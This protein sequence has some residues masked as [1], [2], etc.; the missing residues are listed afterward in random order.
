MSVINTDTL[1]DMGDSIVLGS[2]SSSIVELPRA[3]SLFVSRRTNLIESERLAF[4]GKLLSITDMT[5]STVL[6]V[7]ADIMQSIV[8]SG[9][10][11][12]MVATRTIEA[13]W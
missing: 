11:S 10:L 8:F 6:T 12:N 13:S 4:M 9:G 7:E 3:V 1:D 2:S 5:S